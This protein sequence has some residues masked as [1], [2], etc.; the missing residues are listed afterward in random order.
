MA[1][2]S[3]NTIK[4]IF[5]KTS[6]TPAPSNTIP[7]QE[8]VVQAPSTAV[9]PI[10]NNAQMGLASA[11]GGTTYTPTIDPNPKFGQSGDSVRL[12]QQQL[13]QKNA[14]VPGY[15]PLK[16]DGLYG[17]KTRAVANGP[18]L[19]VTSGTA[20]TTYAKNS[21][22]L[23][24]LLSKLSANSQIKSNTPA[25]EA[26]KDDPILQGLE[27]MKSDN[28]VATQNL[29][30]TTQAMYQN[31]KNKV[32]SQYEN[33]KRGLQ[34]LGIQ[35]NDAQSTPDL[36]S[37]HIQ[38][39]A[40]DQME[41]IDEYDAEKAKAISE[42]NLAK[43]TQNFKLLQTSLDR[44]KELD[45]A[46]L[47]AVKDMHDILKSTEDNA[48]IQAKDI[49]DELV[50]LSPEEKQVYIEAIS[51]QFNIPLN[52][53]TRALADEK[54]NREEKDV[55]LKNKKRLAAGDSESSTSGKMTK[56]NIALGDKKLNASRGKDSYVDPDV[57][58]TAYD[59]WNG[60]LK[61]FLLAYPPEKYVNP[62]NKYLPKYLMPNVDEND[63]AS[64]LQNLT[65][66]DSE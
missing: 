25:S 1:S 45:N 56:Q 10:G 33:Y 14:T 22:E 53:L 51:K 42:A 64:Q 8:T 55:D 12:L 24:A 61:E 30:A 65:F 2:T 48:E 17:P 49:Y 7:T 20:R 13:N 29:I 34:S 5:D 44:I 4:K 63:I 41:K 62:A 32:N 18:A 58:Q 59:E 57:Y 60:T 47:Q 21:A 11:P 31:K 50:K 36:L 40:T 37:G 43:K 16:E 27:T 66:N 15:V 54:Y 3:I 38:K 35:H 39:A 28:D 52:S 23:D 9:S 6:E 46:K 19:S 26:Y